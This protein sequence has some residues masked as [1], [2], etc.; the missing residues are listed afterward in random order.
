MPIKVKAAVCVENFFTSSES[1]AEVWSKAYGR[2]IIN[3]VTLTQTVLATCAQIIPPRLC[4]IKMIG[5]VEVSGELLRPF[6]AF[7]KLFAWSL[8]RLVDTGDTKC[9]TS[10]S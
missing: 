6:K 3:A 2:Q 4:A 7:D 1:I 8:T 9:A 10:A 5:H